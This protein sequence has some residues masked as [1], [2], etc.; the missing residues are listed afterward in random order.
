MSTGDNV[1]D[2]RDSPQKSYNEHG[3][4]SHPVRITSAGTTDSFD[5]AFQRDPSIVSAQQN[6]SEV[7]TQQQS[8]GQ[9]DDFF[10]S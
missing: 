2:G 5:Y 4:S 3:Q 6:P 1:Y 7:Q 8:A 9:K 10:D